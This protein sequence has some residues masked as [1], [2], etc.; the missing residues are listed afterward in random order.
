MHR[1]KE[2]D[3][4]KIHQ[5]H[6]FYLQIISPQCVCG[7]GGHENYNILSPYFVDATNL[8]LAK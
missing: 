3:V 4:L 6:T 7:G 1:C 5:F 2:E 8:K